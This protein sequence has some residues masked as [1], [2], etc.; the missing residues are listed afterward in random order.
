MVEDYLYLIQILEV[1]V[2]FTK[3]GFIEFSE[4]TFYANNKKIGSWNYKME[5]PNTTNF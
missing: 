4:T 1:I 3:N 5:I 2:V